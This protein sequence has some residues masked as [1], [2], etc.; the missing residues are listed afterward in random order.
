MDCYAWK[1]IWINEFSRK[2]DKI[3]QKKYIMRDR[4]II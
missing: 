1:V 4:D 2:K 3:L